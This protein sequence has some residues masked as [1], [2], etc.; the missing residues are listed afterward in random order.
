MQKKKYIAFVGDSFCANYE[1]NAP[2]VQ[3][4]QHRA[5]FPAYPSIT[6]RHYQYNVAPYGFGGRSWWYS[7]SKFWKEWEHKLDQIA[8]IVF[9]HTQNT[10]INSAVIPEFPLMANHADKL[11]TTDMIKANQDYFKYIHDHDFQEWAQESY[12]KMLKEKFNNI[13]TIHLHCF[14]YTVPLSHLLPGVVFTTPLIHISI[15]EIRGSK[16]KI[17]E[18]FNDGRANHLN[19]YNNQVLADIIIQSLDN[20]QPGQYELPVEK[21]EQHNPNAAN[22]PDGKFW[23]K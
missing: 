14:P 19:S 2:G 11:S 3:M 5:D 6:A 4:H 21:F 15:G 12:F 9:A 18:S 20:Y 7:W 23:N 8:A 13:Q 10:R 1:W 17:V 22:W 16:E